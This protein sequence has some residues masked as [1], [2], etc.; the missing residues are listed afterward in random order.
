LPDFAAALGQ[1][2]DGLRVG[3]C[4]NHFFDVDAAIEAAIRFYRDAAPTL[5]APWPM[6]Q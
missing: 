2:I 1:R 6:V 5:P 4:R 3:I